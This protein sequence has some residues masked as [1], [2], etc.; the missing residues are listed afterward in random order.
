M[1][2]SD[3]PLGLLASLCKARTLYLS[4]KGGI[5]DKSSSFEKLVFFKEFLGQILSEAIYI[6]AFY[7]HSTKIGV[8]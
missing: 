8:F 7:I 5:I 2:I 1:L 3:G 6:L 4:I